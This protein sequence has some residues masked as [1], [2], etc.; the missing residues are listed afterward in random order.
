MSRNGRA[1]LII[2]ATSILIAA[3]AVFWT[4]GMTYTP[5]A[6]SYPDRGQ[7]AI[8]ASGKHVTIR[9]SVQQTTN[10]GPH[11]DWLGYQLQPPVSQQ[12]SPDNLSNPALSKYQYGTGRFTVPAHALVTVIV[13]NYDS[14][15]LLRNAYFS[16]VQGTV[17]GVASCTST[18]DAGL[19]SADTAF[20]GGQ[21]FKV[22]PLDLTSHTFTIPQLGVS[23]PIGGIGGDGTKGY[24]TTRFTFRTG[25]PGTY[26]WQCIVPCGVGLY[27]FGGPMSQFGYMNGIF[28]VV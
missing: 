3:V 27:G 26:R 17:G 7:Q 12:P 16:Q 6:Y 23:V 1:V 25:D 10:R 20:C 22:M 15:T 21:N 2:S 9:L 11:G 28:Q 19:T 14:Q 13:H 18:K 24:V 8:A 4:M 5:F